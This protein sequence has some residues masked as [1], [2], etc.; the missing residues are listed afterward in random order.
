MSYKSYITAARRAAFTRG[1]IGGGGG[2]VLPSASGHVNIR[3]HNIHMLT[4]E[5]RAKGRRDLSG[6]S[7]S[8]QC[9]HDLAQQEH[10]APSQQQQQIAAIDRRFSALALSFNDFP[11]IL[12]F[13][14]KLHTFCVWCPTSGRCACLPMFL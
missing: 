13:F 3:E 14:R 2:G 11:M 6:D 4:I 1:L 9:S 8:A 7:L 12:N 10:S 5:T